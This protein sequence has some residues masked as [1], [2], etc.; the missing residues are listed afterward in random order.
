MSWLG[1]GLASLGGTGTAIGAGLLA[2]LVAVLGVL[3]I[4]N[5]A[6][7]QGVAE[8]KAQATEAHAAATNT[9]NAATTAHNAAVVAQ[10]EQTHEV[11]DR[12]DADAAYRSSVRDRFTRPD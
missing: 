11:H 2:L 1:A 4:K 6:K 8:G 3:G 12:L 7:K 9:A 5:S 10:V